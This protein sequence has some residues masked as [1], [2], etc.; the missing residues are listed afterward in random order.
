V[1]VWTVGA[2]GRAPLV[3][4]GH[5]QPITAL[6]FTADGRRL[7]SGSEDATVRLWDLAAADPAAAPEVLRGHGEPVTDLALVPRRGWLASASEDGTVHL[8]D[9]AVHPAA[10]Q[11]GLHGHRG[12]VTCL[13]VGPAG[14]LIVTGSED[15]TARVWRL[16]LYERT[17]GELAARAHAVA[18]RDLSAGE[19]ARFHLD[20]R[21]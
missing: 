16:D 8:W 2:P 7:A 13:A 19:L 5:E 4:A 18:G 20:D 12:D 11:G 3:L 1:R 15:R 17:L 6:V 14:D 21:P 9:L 10:S